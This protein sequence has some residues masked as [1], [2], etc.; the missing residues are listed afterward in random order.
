VSK[1][2]DT[3]LGRERWSGETERTERTHAQRA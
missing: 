1:L 3:M 2:I